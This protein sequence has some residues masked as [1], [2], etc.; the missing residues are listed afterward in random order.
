MSYQV[1]KEEKAQVREVIAACIGTIGLPEGQ[2]CI[3]SL[4]KL[5]SNSE[6][7]PNVKA[8][9]AWSIGRLASE[10]TGQKVKKIIV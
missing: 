9:V 2:S 3:D 10:Q 6:E 8:M 4:I 1:L 5:L 7:D